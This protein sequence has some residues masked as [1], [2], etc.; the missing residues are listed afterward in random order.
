ML[1]MNDNIH[2]SPFNDVTFNLSV[3]ICYQNRNIPL[4]SQCA[5]SFYHKWE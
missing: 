2:F 3:D 4:Y 5:V 1:N